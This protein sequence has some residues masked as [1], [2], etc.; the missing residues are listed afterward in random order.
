M[1]RCIAFLN[2]APAILFYEFKSDNQVQNVCQVG[3]HDNLVFLTITAC[4][5]FFFPFISICSLNLAVYLNIRK[6]S[7]GLIRTKPAAIILRTKLEYDDKEE[8][9]LN[10][11]STLVNLQTIKKDRHLHKDRKAARCVL[12]IK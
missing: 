8:K 7:K 3:F 4:V 1:K 11:E 10:K 5:E 12:K 2:Y 6:R 9:Q